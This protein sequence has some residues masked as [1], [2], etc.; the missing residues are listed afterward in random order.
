MNGSNSRLEDLRGCSLVRVPPK[1]LEEMRV[2]NDNDDDTDD[3]G[4]AYNNEGGFANDLNL[5]PPQAQ[6]L[7]RGPKSLKS[8]WRGSKCTTTQPIIK[9][10]T[11]WGRQTPLAPFQLHDRVNLGRWVNEVTFILPTSAIVVKEGVQR[12]IKK[13]WFIITPVA[14][15]YGDDD[16]DDNDG[17]DNLSHKPT[18]VTCRNGKSQ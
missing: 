9:T 18:K 8:S 4:D 1:P 3:Y 12:K 16:D 15:A 13:Q 14:A 5:S 2:S 17:T 7:L 11:F 6:N 10:F